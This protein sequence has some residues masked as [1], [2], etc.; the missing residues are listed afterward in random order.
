[1]SSQTKNALVAMAV[2][3][4]CTGMSFGFSH[5]FPQG[6]RWLA[7]WQL[8]HL[9]SPSIASSIVLVRAEGKGPALCGE[10][11]WNLNALEAAF[12]ALHQ[13]GASVIAPMIDVSVPIPSECG[14]LSG[15]VHLAEVTKHVGSVVYPDSVPSALAQAAIRT[16]PLRLASDD[17]GIVPGS[18]FNSSSLNSLSRPFGAAVAALASTS[19]T[20]AVTGA[21]LYVPGMMPKKGESLFP[22]YPFT[23]LW[24]LIQAGER[25]KLVHLFQGKIVFLYSGSSIGFALSTPR[26]SRVPVALFHAKLANAYLT[27]SWVSTSPF[28]V[29]FL[30]TV[31]LGGLLTVPMFRELSL[32]RLGLIGLAI[33]LLAS[34][35]LFFGFHWGWIWPL[36]SMGLSVGMTIVGTGLWRFLQSRATVQERIAR[37]EKQLT[38]LE[39][40]FAGKQNHVRQLEEQLYDAQYQTN[41]SVTVIEELQVSQNTALFQLERYQDE[42][43]ETRRKMNRL[44]EELHDLRQHAPASPAEFSSEALTVEHQGLIQ[45]CEALQI[46]TRDQAVLRLFQNLKKAAATQVP[47]LIL[48]ETGTGK[49]VFAKAAHTMSSCRQGPFISVNM[50][51]I[52]SEL[53]EGELFGHV[54]GAFT[55]AVGR[56]G[57]LESAHGGT[58]FLDEVG[59]LP[60][61]LQAKLLRFLE[62]G[63]FHRVGQSCVTHVD[64]RIIAATNRDLQHE[65]QAGRYREDLYYRLRGMVLTLPPLRLRNQADHVMLAQS[66]LQQCAH[67][68]HRTDLAFTQGALDAILAHQWPGNIRELRQ[69][70]SQAVALANGPVITEA[71]LNLAPPPTLLVGENWGKEDLGRRE[72]AMVLDCLRRHKFEMQATAAAL[73]W[74]RGTVTQRLKGVGFQALMEYQGNIQ[75]AARALAGDE[76][77]VRVV[78]GRL[79][80]YANNLVPPSKHYGSVEEAIADCRKRFRNLP[81]RHFPAV[82]QLIQARFASL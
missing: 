22:T 50:A 36:F 26:E 75:A 73:G 17:N 10:G 68:Q 25:E 44:Q 1:M 21:F 23:D 52:R 58:L 8:S 20:A 6:E 30:V 82:E 11:R 55:G 2:V 31:S 46:M 51:A 60:L 71:D 72:D 15:L 76:R 70:I 35:F 77:F 33:A 34:G 32:S 41:Q 53:F 12:L 64:A 59:D 69:T 56:T 78:E 65:V 29:A 54:K 74:D 67:V 80:E 5:I 57:F 14:G 63:G 3:L 43:Q 42:M 38:Q 79:R 9:S 47:I 48:G 61:D 81:E 66:F 49:E 62:D 37:G 7:E 28:V 19:E 39:Y 4:C 16:G 40:E 13:A 24:S 18:I 45:E 27:N